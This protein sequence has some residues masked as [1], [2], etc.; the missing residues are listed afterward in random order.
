MSLVFQQFWN[1][2]VLFFIFQ[3]MLR[4]SSWEPC[5]MQLLNLAAILTFLKHDS[6][7]LP[8]SRT[9]SYSQCL[10]HQ[11]QSQDTL[12]SSGAPL[13]S[14]IHALSYFL[15][16]SPLQWACEFSFF[17]YLMGQLQSYL[18]LK[19]LL[20]H[21]RNHGVFYSTYSPK[22]IMRTQL[23]FHVT[24]FYLVLFFNTPPKWN[25]YCLE[26]PCEGLL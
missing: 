1:F 10:Q 11:D 22:H 17:S 2:L 6:I 13:P 18:F 4:I 23:S 16:I 20:K 25:S 12:C 3:I 24:A 5:F 9:S 15:T 21:S 7:Q 19:W 8:N 14:P 26:K